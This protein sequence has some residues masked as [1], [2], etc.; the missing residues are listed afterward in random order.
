MKEIVDLLVKQPPVQFGIGAAKGTGRG[1]YNLVDKL[2]VD[3]M[4][5]GNYESWE[6]L[7]E[8][9]NP[10]PKQQSIM[11]EQ[12]GKDMPFVSELAHDVG[13][14]LGGASFE[15]G[16]AAA[17][18]KLPS[19]NLLPAESATSYLTGSQEEKDRLIDASLTG[20]LGGAGLAGSHLLTQTAQAVNN[21]YHFL[22]PKTSL[23]SF[24]K[25]ELQ[26]NSLYGGALEDLLKANQ[27]Y[28]EERYPGVQFSTPQ[29]ANATSFAKDGY[30]ADLPLSQYAKTFGSRGGYEAIPLQQ[31]KTQDM[32]VL[33]GLKE[34]SG[35]KPAAQDDF[36]DFRPPEPG[37][38]IRQ[39]A[40]Q[41]RRAQVEPY[42]AIVDGDMTN[43][44]TQI[45]KEFKKLRKER[46]SI[47]KAASQGKSIFKDMGGGST[48][49]DA[50]NSGTYI[51]SI[52][53]SLN[54]MENVSRRQGKVG[55]SK[56]IRSAKNAFSDLLEDLSPE[57][58]QGN[59][60]Y[61]E[62]S[63]PINQMD[64]ADFILNKSVPKGYRN[65]LSATP[66]GTLKMNTIREFADDPD[67]IVQKVLQR[68]KKASEV[69]NQEFMDEMAKLNELSHIQETTKSGLR[70]QGSPTVA[71]LK[72]TED[73]KK[74]VNAS[75]T[76][77]SPDVLVRMANQ[78]A[79]KHVSSQTAKYDQRLGEALSDPQVALEILQTAP[80]LL[81][82]NKIATPSIIGAIMAAENNED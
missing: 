18:R 39:Y 76:P 17:G 63:V 13:D 69:L 48:T 67:A 16:T 57:I 41:Y 29:V 81:L 52:I 40:E 3:N 4:L 79:R 64:V 19:W 65:N 10:D 53:Q 11:D 43:Y 37:E 62:S 9:I 12:R 5:L 23:D 55:K 80:N 44:D 34:Y 8:R 59:R 6:K 24:V 32:F 25:S 47:K 73:L 15:L 30:D 2:I 51:S 7:G 56:G 61:Y 78:L 33:D 54:D 14:F 1:L 77:L 72:Q 38:S 50:L 60:L 71:N 20:M 58:L 74:K 36:P 35:R 46:P 21:A 31:Q 66:P 68:P 75:L 82:E 27:R 42:Y 70:S 45:G 49:K 26:Q 22:N 28:L